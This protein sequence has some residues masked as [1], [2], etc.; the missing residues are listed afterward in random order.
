DLNRN[1][2]DSLNLTG[3]DVRSIITPGVSGLINSA[4]MDAARAVGIRYAVTDTS[5]VGCDNP[6]PNLGFYNTYAPDILLVPRRPTNL[7]YNVST[8]AQWTSEYN[9]IYRAYWGRDLTYNEVLDRESDVLL[10]Y[11]LRGELDPWMF[12]Q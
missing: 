11:L 12:H 8:P 6:R 9:D 7:F 10:T 5:R 2:A 4:V 1:A 3:F